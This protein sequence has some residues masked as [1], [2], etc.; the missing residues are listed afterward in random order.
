MVEPL[1][2]T[3][4]VSCADELTCPNFMGSYIRSEFIFATEAVI[5]TLAMRVPG[6]PLVSRDSEVLD[7]IEVRYHTFTTRFENPHS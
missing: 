6:S 1:E 7:E 5:A 4:Y 3:R 2:E